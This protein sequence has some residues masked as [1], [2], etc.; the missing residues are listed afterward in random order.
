MEKLIE[1]VL[2]KI[3]SLLNSKDNFKKQVALLLYNWVCYFFLNDN[4]NSTLMHKWIDLL[5]NWAEL[6]TTQQQNTFYENWN[7][8]IWTEC[9]KLDFENLTTMIQKQ[10]NIK[11]LKCRLSKTDN[12]F[13]WLNSYYKLL[14]EEKIFIENIVADKYA[15]IPNQ[16]GK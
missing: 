3:L 5:S 14:N 2:V 1:D 15:V 16:N 10:E 12:P 4:F 8:V 13:I 6:L 9:K 11:N 7:K